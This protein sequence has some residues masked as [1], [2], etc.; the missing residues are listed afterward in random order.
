MLADLMTL[1]RIENSRGKRGVNLTA[2]LKVGCYNYVVD[3]IACLGSAGWAL[4]REGHLYP[5]II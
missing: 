3:S 2:V 4:N 1:S 5:P